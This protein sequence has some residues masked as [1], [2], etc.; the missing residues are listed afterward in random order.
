MGHLEYRFRF[1]VSCPIGCAW[2]R[3][4]LAYRS[5]GTKAGISSRPPIIPRRA[6]EHQRNISTIFAVETSRCAIFGFFTAVVS[7]LFCPFLL[8]FQDHAVSR[9]Q[10]VTWLQEW[11]L[12]PI[13]IGEG[14]FPSGQQQ[15]VRD[16]LQSRCPRIEMT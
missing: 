8:V 2:P 14:T 10:D 1:Y 6:I 11:A 5:C 12:T 4:P 16:I 7:L 15:A 9:F 13:V 3:L